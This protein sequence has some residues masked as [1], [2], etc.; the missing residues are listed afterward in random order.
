MK[1]PILSALALAFLFVATTP[2]QTTI[3]SGGRIVRGSGTNM[4][5]ESFIIGLDGQRGVLNGPTLTNHYNHITIATL[6]NIYHLNITNT[7]SQKILTNRYLITNALAAYGSKFGGV[8][9]YFGQN[10]HFGAYAGNWDLNGNTY[11]LVITVVN[12]ADGSFNGTYYFTVPVPENSTQWS[13]FMSNGATQVC[14]VPGLTTTFAATGGNIAT[15]GLTNNGGFLLSHVADSSSTNYEYTIW[16]SGACYTNNLVLADNGYGFWDPLYTLAFDAPPAN[17]PSFVRQPQFQGQPLPPSYEGKSLTE[18]L[19][20]KAVVTNAVSSA[21]TNWLDLDN[22]PELRDQP[23][24][25]QF[26]TDMGSNA[27]ALASYVFNRIQLTDAVAY[28]GNTNNPLDP[29]VNLGG[30]NRSAYATFMEGQG[31]PTEQCALLIYL[32]RRAGVP[33]AYIYGPTD[34][35]QMLDTRLSALLRMQIHGAVDANGNLYTTNTLISVNYPWVA[36]Y[37]NGQWIHLFPWLKDTQITE[38][39]NLYD[40]LPA[41][42]NNAYKWIKQYLSGDTNILSLNESDEP[43]VLF[44][45]FI[46][47]SLLT[48]GPGLSIDDMGTQAFDRQVEYNQWSDFPTPF[49]VTNG[50][51]STIHDLTTITTNSGFAGWTNIWDTFSVQVASS[52]APSKS[53][54]TGDL[55]VADLQDRKFLIRQQTNTSGGYTL[56]LSLAPYRPALTNVFAFTNDTNLLNQETLTLTLASTD[57]PINVTFNRKRHRTAPIN[58]SQTNYLSVLETLTNTHVHTLRLGDLGAICLHSGQV[59]KQMLLPWAQEYWAMQQAVK[60]NPSLTNTL[61]PDITQGT[62]PYLMGMAYYERLDHIRPTLEQLHKVQLDSVIGQGLSVLSAG[63]NTSGTLQLPLVLHHPHVDMLE[64]SINTYANTTLRPD[65]GFDAGQA[66]DDFNRMYITAGSA[67]E[68]KVI[69]DFYSQEGGISTDRLLL[70]SPGTNLLELN[71]ENYASHSSLSGYDSSMWA[72]VTNAFASNQFANV[73]ITA[74]P[75]T[76]TAVGYSGMG[77]LICGFPKYSA[78]ISGNGVPANGGWGVPLAFP[79]YIRP[80]ASRSSNGGSMTSPGIA[81]RSSN[82]PPMPVA[83]QFGQLTAGRMTASAGW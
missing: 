5:N 23:T 80:A 64:V 58:P 38:G 73:F 66:E 9:L 69:E 43:S 53:I 32:L 22:S 48:T 11:P 13:T 50:A 25:D 72:A 2:A 17:Q 82:V 56:T 7:L 59:S 77:A 81:S 49:A 28:S 19:A 36:A 52:N 67:E 14:P 18:L 83:S 40:Y 78:L 30:I 76:N 55:R 70:Q 60:A 27:L 21:A 35:I 71:W 15:W 26:V 6:T 57:D 47:Q 16:M 62:L 61:S 65:E 46:T 3:T 51:V 79:I 34:G 45:A 4:A 8:P 20:A 41:N 29:S 42:Y 12:R 75:V 54:S 74:K 33:A 44:P 37:V 39:L 10:Y 24:L 31:S 63:R 68:H 1:K